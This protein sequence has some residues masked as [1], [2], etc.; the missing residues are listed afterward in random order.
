MTEQEPRISAFNVQFSW[1]SNKK[2]L[3]FIRISGRRR[4]PFIDVRR[5][6]D[7][8]LQTIFQLVLSSTTS[9]ELLI[10]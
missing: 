2:V 3:A 5:V 10:A 9:A 6:A 7:G 8:E 4:L 1:F